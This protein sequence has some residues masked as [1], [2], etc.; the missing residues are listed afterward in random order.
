MKVSFTQSI[1][2]GTV[3]GVT[4]QDVTVQGVT[5][6]GDTVQCVAIQGATM[7]DVTVHGVTVQDVTVQ[8]ARKYF[9][10]YFNFNNF[11]K[12]LF[13]NFQDMRRWNRGPI[14]DE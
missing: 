8:G 2:L 10:Y 7:Q 9:C 6:Q 13:Q 12:V 3:H 14:L 4:I 11:L 5:I 1:N